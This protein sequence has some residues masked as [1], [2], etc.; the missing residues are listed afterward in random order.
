MSTTTEGSAPPPAPPRVP[1]RY[2]RRDHGKWLAG[3]ATGMS[4]ALGIDVTVI[5]V[6]WVIVAIA[7]FGVG[8][9]A[10][11]LFWIAFPSERHPAPISRFRH[12]REWSNGY[13]I[14]IVL[15]G[16]GLVI[17]VGQ[18]FAMQP[19]HHFGAFAWAT[20]LIGGGAAVL[21][22]RNPDEHDDSP[23]PPPAPDTR[24]TEPA[25]ESGPDAASD[26][27]AAPA[28]P[29]ALPLSP[30]APAPPAPPTTSAWTQHAPWPAPPPR[31]PRPPRPRRRP[32]LTP[33]TLSALLIGGGLVA[34][35]NDADVTHITTAEA[36]A[37]AVCVI[38][39][40]L[41]VSTRFGR[42]R[43]LIPIGILLLL[44][45]IPASVIDVPITGGVGDRS[46]RPTT[47]AQVHSSYELGI[48]QLDLDLRDL[49]LSDQTLA[50]DAQVG[51]G[52]L[53][54]HVPSTA[55]VEVHAHAGAGQLA[56]FGNTFDDNWPVNATFNAPSTGTGVIEIDASVG[57]GQV[58]VTRY[59][60]NG[61]ETPI[62]R[63][64][65]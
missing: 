56:L 31:P 50:I 32:F 8:V 61:F 30:S 18:L 9:A 52:Q 43:G 38:G 1:R 54:I 62:D 39:V 28:A 20:V 10:Y 3:V 19:Y 47:V 64:V 45:T 15:L 24:A 27:D 63:S 11:L 65:P 53:D 16:I 42:A 13:V 35:L 4:D 49:P 60:A 57:A 36:L 33:L 17:V 37:G 59:D 46:Y 21:L 14:G 51:I 34:L 12:V 48:G 2:V 41:L 29:T 22:L 25:D 44:V 26:P 58:Q 55:R 40:A 23:S 7:S 6:L 5:R